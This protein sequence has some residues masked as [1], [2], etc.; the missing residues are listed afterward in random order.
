MKSFKQL[1]LFF[2]F[3]ASV[4][5]TAQQVVKVDTISGNTVKISM[6]QKISDMLESVEGKCSRTTKSGD[7]DYSNNGTYIPPRINLP[8]RAISTAEA[9]RKNPRIL[10]TK[11]L[12]NTVKSN[13]E[14]NQVAL[15][16]R[17]K[18]PMLKVTKDASL[19]PNYKIMAGSYFT[20]E[21][22]LAD[23]NSVRRVFKEAR[24]V[25]YQIFCVEAK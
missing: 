6:D 9:C 25:S 10:G 17:S 7:S 20:K 23:Y 18:F 12:V 3:F 13:E 19:R 14:A 15:Y 22:A 1:F 4:L 24:L 11:I 21:S 16:F 2:G 5:I 8:D